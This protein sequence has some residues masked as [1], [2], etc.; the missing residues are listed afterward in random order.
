M[1]KW[2]ISEKEFVI[3]TLLLI[4]TVVSV[5]CAFKAYKHQKK[6]AQKE[7]SCDLA[8]YY[9]SSI[10]DKYALIMHVFSVAGLDKKTKEIF[11]Y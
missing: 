4:F 8:K 7:L 11:D 6:R 3:S 5:L 10:I 9:A 2:I 1:F